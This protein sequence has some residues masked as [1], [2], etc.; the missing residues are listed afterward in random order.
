MKRFSG[1]FAAIIAVI[2]VLAFVLPLSAGAVVVGD[3]E[4]SS[5]GAVVLDFDTNTVLFGH[6]EA[7]QRVPASMI[8]MVGVYVIYD[9]IRDGL[10][11]FDTGVL[12]SA[13][14]SEFSRDR[15]YSNVPLKEGSYVSVRQLLEVIMVRSASAAVVALGEGV[16]G[17]ERAFVEKMN[18][19][20]RDMN[21]RADIRDSWGGSPDNRIS[22]LALAWIVRALLLEYPEVLEI[23][24]MDEVTFDGATLPTSNFLLSRYPGADG[25]KT[26]FTNPA[27]Y[28]LIGTAVRDGRRLITVTMGNSLETRYPDTETLLDFGFANADRIIAGQPGVT[29]LPSG[30][31]LPS[32][33]NLTVNGEL[34]P[35]SAYNIKGSHYFKLRDIACLLSD[36]GSQFEVL[37]DEVRQQISIISGETYTPVGGELEIAADTVRSYSQTASDIFVDG[38]QRGFDAYHIEGNNYFRLRDI[39]EL[40]GFR[41]DWIEA[42]LTVII[43]TG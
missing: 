4:I 38:E 29:I 11:T 28:C 16:F 22:P 34:M 40:M 7:V 30:T 15:T 35:L 33:A 17:S 13:G 21:I 9:A 27:G 1:K 43:T 10:V 2:I 36:T 5:R 20:A 18:A 41:V 3:S 32:T 23:T 39:A 42:T 26:G 31:V 25:L 12:I 19:K 24:S 8:K 14:V 37:W 6:N